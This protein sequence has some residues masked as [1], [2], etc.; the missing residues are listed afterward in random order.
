MPQTR[1]KMIWSFSKRT[2]QTNSVNR[3][4]KRTQQTDTVW[5]SNRYQIQYQTQHQTDS[6][7]ICL[8]ELRIISFSVVNMTEK[9][10]C[11]QLDL[12]HFF[13]MIGNIYSKESKRKFKKIVDVFSFFA[14]TYIF[15][16]RR[17]DSLQNK[18]LKI[19]ILRTDIWD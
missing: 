1:V 16:I 15:L 13:S 18:L 5:L 7:Y 12:G 3:H 14:T 4:S 8:Q 11:C 19:R 17:N 10:R 2:Q 6:L 9:L